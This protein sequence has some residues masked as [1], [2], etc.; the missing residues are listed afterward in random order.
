MRGNS[1][2]IA[3][4]SC[5]LS[6]GSIGLS[7]MCRVNPATHQ[8]YT[9]VSKV[10]SEFGQFGVQLSKV[11]D[12]VGY[13]TWQFFTWSFDRPWTGWMDYACIAAAVLFFVVGSYLPDVD[14]ENSK[15]G[16]YVHLPFKHRTWTHTIYSVLLFIVAG[17]AFRPFFWLAFG[18]FGHL[19]WDGLSRGG[20]C[21]FNPVTG[22]IEYPSGAK[23]KRGHKAK[24]YRVGSVSEYVVVTL[25]V[26]LAVVLVCMV[27]IPA[28]KTIQW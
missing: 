18:Y 23:V 7:L 21:W 25:L 28:W 10:V 1:H 16:R 12:E 11:L 2:L 4:I 20:V 17:F 5:G 3:N 13:G 8:S 27:G 19:F 6:L 14:Q 26:A 9:D 22:Y 15:L 24:L